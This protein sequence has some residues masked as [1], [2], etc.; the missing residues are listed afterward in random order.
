MK[1]TLDDMEETM[2]SFAESRLQAASCEME[3]VGG[4]N[5]S[6]PLVL[7]RIYEI[8]PPTIDSLVQLATVF[9]NHRE[10]VFSSQG[11]EVFRL[12]YEG[13]DLGEAFKEHP[14]LLDPCLK[15]CY[16]VLLKKLT[17]PSTSSVT[18]EAK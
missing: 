4:M 17:A 13:Q 6:N 11:T 8:Q 2:Q 16:N 10:V 14:E 7:L 18:A 12:R 5:E 9:L 3:V 15:N 1:Y